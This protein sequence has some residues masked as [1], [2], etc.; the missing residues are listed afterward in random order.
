M[1]REERVQQATQALLEAWESGDM[2]EAIQRSTI[3]RQ[4]GDRPCEQ[5]SLGNYLI[6]LFS[7][8]QDAR[9]FRQWE[10]AGRK[11]KK[12]SKALYILGPCMVKKRDEKTGEDVSILV[13]FK[14]IPVFRLEDTEG[15][16]VEIPNYEPPAQPPLAQVAEQWGLKVSYGPATGDFYGWYNGK[17]IHL[18][19]HDVEVFFHELTHAAHD[20]IGAKKAKPGQDPHREIVAETAAAV[21]ARLYGYPG[22][23]VNARSYVAYY[24]GCEPKKVA[25]QVMKHLGDI[26]KCLE[27]ILTTAGELAEKELVAA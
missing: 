27:L 8:T 16:P 12:G 23:E 2:P 5:W 19:S 9:G 25:Q 6:T 7:G 22:R 18:A 26:Q 3:A 20:R 24:A 21:L 13:G 1:D 4:V 11:V 10:K 14:S 17:Q 15:D